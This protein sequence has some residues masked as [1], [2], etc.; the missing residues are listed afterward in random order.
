MLH[1]STLLFFCDSSW[2]LE[3]PWTL[4]GRRVTA[5]RRRVAAVNPNNPLKTTKVSTNLLCQIRGGITSF[6]SPSLHFL[7]PSAMPFSVRFQRHLAQ[8]RV[9]R[10][11]LLTQT[12][13]ATPAHKT[14]T[15]RAVD[16][17]GGDL[18]AKRSLILK[19]VYSSC[20]LIAGLGLNRSA[21][22]R[23]AATPHA[24]SPNLVPLSA[25]SA[26]LSLFPTPSWLL[27]SVRPVF[28]PRRNRPDLV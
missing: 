9:Q 12:S 11:R 2:P 18:P 15:L 10:S 27:F 14:K 24:A 1:N 7:D 28:N 19:P 17:C 23:S 20:F 6:Q 21:L 3:G 4:T 26:F 22:E 13:H 16:F 5:D 8:T 25:A